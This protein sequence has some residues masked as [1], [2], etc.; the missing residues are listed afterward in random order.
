MKRHD[1]SLGSWASRGSLQNVTQAIGMSRGK[2]CTQVTIREPGG[3]SR[4]SQD[5]EVLADSWRMNGNYSSKER[6]GK[7]I[8]EKEGPYYA[9]LEVRKS[10]ELMESSKDA[11]KRITQGLIWPS[12]V[13][14]SLAKKKHINSDGCKQKRGLC[15]CKDWGR[16]V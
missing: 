15:N 13:V 16:V 4:A 10:L 12:V 8:P 1:R 5:S 7:E 2:C 14:K 9:S 6:K 3:V 11:E